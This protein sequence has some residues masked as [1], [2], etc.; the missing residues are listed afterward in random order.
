MTK[1]LSKIIKPYCLRNFA[2][3]STDEFI[4]IIKPNISKGILALRD[5]NSL[6]PNVPKDETIDIIIKQCYNHP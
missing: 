6:F 1:T 4:D 2:I 5:V 3:N